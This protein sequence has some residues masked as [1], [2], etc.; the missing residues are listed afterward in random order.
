MWFC[1]SLLLCLLLLIFFTRWWRAAWILS[2]LHR[3]QNIF[4]SVFSV[5]SASDLCVFVSVQTATS[6]QSFVSDWTVPALRP[7]QCPVHELTQRSHDCLQSPE[8][9]VSPVRRTRPWSGPCPPA[10]PPHRRR[11]PLPADRKHDVIS[12]V[13]MLQWWRLTLRP[14]DGRTE[15]NRSKQTGSFQ[16]TAAGHHHA[17][18]RESNFQ[19]I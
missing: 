3:S 15:G 12:V 6:E 18:D 10:P 17:N 1:T 2:S 13:M 5:V 14:T 19:F 8:R 9:A 4:I 7:S 11:C 16:A